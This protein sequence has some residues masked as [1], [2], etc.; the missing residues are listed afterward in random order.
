MTTGADPAVEELVW[1]MTSY[2]ERGLDE[3][4]HDRFEEH[5]TE[6]LGCRRYLD[7]LRTVV[8][9]LA[10]TP[11][12]ELSPVARESVLEAFRARSPGRPHRRPDATSVTR[13]V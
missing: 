13:P 11:R 3:V 12:W 4:T 7:Q 10:R 5:L 2:L 8:E 1:L 6:C 9:L